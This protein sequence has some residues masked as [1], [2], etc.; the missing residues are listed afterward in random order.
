MENIT[1]NLTGVIAIATCVS[2]AFVW[3]YINHI[4]DEMEGLR[5]RIYDLENKMEE[6]NPTLR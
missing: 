4:S 6:I 5:N 1:I 2:I 3:A